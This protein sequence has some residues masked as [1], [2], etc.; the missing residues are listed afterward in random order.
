MKAPLEYGRG[1]EKTCIYG[2]LHGYH[3]KE[4]TSCTA[5]CNCANHIELLEMIEA[6]PQSLGDHLPAAR[7]KKL[8]A[9]LGP[10]YFDR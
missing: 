6:D 2:T 8:Y 5:S 9:D 4:P 3:G 1:L 7:A 10:D